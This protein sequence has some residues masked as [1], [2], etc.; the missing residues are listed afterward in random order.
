MQ[1]SSVLVVK[2]ETG[3]ITEAEDDGKL[4]ASVIKETEDDG[5]FETDVI[6]GIENYCSLETDIITGTEDDGV[7]SVLVEI[8]L[9]S[10]I[11]VVG[12]LS[13]GMGLAVITFVP[14]I[15]DESDNKNT[16]NIQY[17]NCLMDIPDTC[18]V[19]KGTMVNTQGSV[20]MSYKECSNSSL[21]S[22]G[23]S[24]D[25]VAGLPALLASEDC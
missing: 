18:C 11:V 5:R 3:A 1:S 16:L 9:T 23:T 4:K 21:L 22:C 2:L 10:S 17:E 14:T 7:S 8:S 13:F 6:T 19:G 20:V 15:V 24:S 12:V 25:P